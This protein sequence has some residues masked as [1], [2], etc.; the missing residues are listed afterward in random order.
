MLNIENIKTTIAV[1]S[2]LIAASAG[3]YKLLDSM[4]FNWSRPVLTW[5]PDHFEISSARVDEE[6]R[7]IVA[8]EKHRDDCEVTGFSISIRDSNMMMHPATPGMTVFAGPASETVEMFAYSFFVQEQHYEMV[9]AGTATFMGRITYECP[10]GTQY[11]D[12]P[13]GLTFNILPIE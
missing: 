6:F 4:G 8:R 5:A 9:S 3:G 7:I 11:V 2:G 1:V 10:E 13:T 12:Y